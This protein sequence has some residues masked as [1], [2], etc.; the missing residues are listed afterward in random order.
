[1]NEKDGSGLIKRTKRFLLAIQLQGLLAVFWLLLIPKEAGS[2]GLL[3]FSY[4]RLALL[5]VLLLA[6]LLA[7]LL[8][9][10]LKKRSAWQSVII[11]DRG[12]AGL[13][14]P[15]MVG[16]FLLALAGWCIA[17]FFHFLGSHQPVEF[18]LRLLPLLVYGFAI[19]I[20]SLLF[21]TLVWLGERGNRHNLKFNMLFGKVFWIAL[22]IFV[23]IWLVIHL[24]GLGIAPEFVSIISLNVPLLEGQVWFMA[25]MI[26]L[27]LCLANGMARLPERKGKPA[28]VRAD[29]LI[30]VALWALAAGLWLTLPLPRNNYFAPQVLPP[31]YS[32]YP[33]SDA[34]QYD[35][36][37]IWVWKGAIRDIVISKPLYVAFLSLLHALVGLDYGKVILLQT[38]VLALLPVVMYLIGKEMHSRLGGI[39]LALFVILREM[40]S[41]QAVNFAN[42]SNSKLLLSDTPA[43]LLVAILLLLTIRWFKSPPEKVGKYPFLIAGLVACLNL[44]RIQTLLLEPVFLVLLVVRYWKRYRQLLQ[45]LGLVLLALALVLS[46]VLMRNHAI[47]GVYWLDNPATSSALYRFFLDENTSDLD[48]PT[49]ETEQD[50]LNR[51]ITVITQVLS[52]N[53]GNLAWSI[54]DNFMH[55]VIS[56]IL[57]FPVRLGNP[58]GILSYLRIDK[59]FWG[60]VYSR[61]NWLNFI[62]LLI[63]LIIVSVG[64]ASAARK[65]IPTIFLVWSFYVIY[66]A[67]SAL[68]RISGWRFIQPVDWLV[69]AFFSFGLVDLLRTAVSYLFRQ[70]D[71]NALH[72]LAQSSSE[73]KSL[74]LKW[75]TVVIFGLVF[76]V[77]GAYVPLR[78]KLFPVDYPDYTRTEVCEAFQTALVGSPWEEQQDELQDFCMQE[79]VRAYKGIG[80]SPRFFKDGTGF[81]KRTYDPFFGIQD[82]GRLVFRTVGEPNTK[83]YIKTDDENIRFPDGVEVYVMGEEKTKFEARAVLILGEEN[84][85]IVSWPEDTAA[86]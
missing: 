39:T 79:N 77:S 83:V 64:I 58:V 72:F 42:V 11:D 28:W 12:R 41:I 32:I 70:E 84:Q 61:A 73:Q 82:Y 62:N 15:L 2:T 18:F 44:I 78:E 43:T 85:L 40:N 36:N 59:P 35:L 54:A 16:S 65:H 7:E 66:S 29:L 56:T 9:W 21:I 52:Q 24:T 17:F 38:L 5:A 3:G 81:Y 55:N 33:F 34:E 60:E 14:R 71:A 57:I 1:M 80:I 27:I 50:I 19:G 75:S 37:A 86:E 53:F 63:N 13:S 4:K 30:C 74:A 20:E 6:M 25:G 26:V 48:I 69:I 22:A 31:N 46:P 51:N 45:S 47:T 68:V 67:S 76:L 8:T 23:V 10:Q 49:V